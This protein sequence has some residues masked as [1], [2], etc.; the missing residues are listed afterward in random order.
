MAKRCVIVA[1]THIDEM[2]F[3]VCPVFIGDTEDDGKSGRYDLY[4]NHRNQFE[5]GLGLMKNSGTAHLKFLHTMW[6]NLHIKVCHDV[7]RT[8]STGE[9]G[10]VDVLL[11]PSF[12]YSKH[13]R[14]GISHKAIENKWV[15]GISRCNDQNHGDFLIFSK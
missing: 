9:F 6:G 3:N 11:V 1:G 13:F 14:S 4:K 2:G 7:N 5:K 10:N 15:F 8:D 12:N